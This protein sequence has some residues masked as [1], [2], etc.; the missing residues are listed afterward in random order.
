MRPPKILLGL[1]TKDNDSQRQQASEAQIACRRLGIDLTIQYADGDAVTQSQQ[2]LAAIQ[3]TSESRPDGIIF[4]PVSETG[5]PQVARA[6]LAAKVGWCVLDLRPS[7]LGDLY[8]TASAVVFG[9]GC[10]QLEVGRIQGK[11]L[12][13]M[14]PQGGSVLVIQGA[15]ENL[16]AKQ[17]TRGLEEA[18]PRDV[19]LRFIKGKWTEESGYGAIKSYLRLATA[20]AA[21]IQCIVAQCDVMAMG[22]KRALEEVQN[23]PERQKW[24]EVPFIG[25]DGL[26]ETGQAWVNTMKLMATVIVPPTGGMAVQMMFDALTL[27]KRPPEYSLTAPQSFPSIERLK[28]RGIGTASSG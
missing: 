19:Q 21:E 14:L 25:A 24:L 1:I 18:K 10:D 6:A 5:L 17:R 16:T 22:A 20:R 4:D 26:P 13:R 9:V 8:Q 11:Q 3:S 27:N 15:L 7:Y 12:A 28:P 2:L 23:R